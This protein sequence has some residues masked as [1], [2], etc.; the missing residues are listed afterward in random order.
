MADKAALESHLKTLRALPTIRQ[1]C[2]LVHALAQ[3]NKLQYFEYHPEKEHEVVMFCEEIMRRDYESFSKAC[4]SHTVPVEEQCARLLDLFLVSVLLDAGA[5]NVWKYKEEIENGEVYSRS[6]GLAIASLDMF[7]KGLFS[8]D[9]EMKERVDAQGLSSLDAT[10]VGEG[11]Q[12]NARNPLSGLEGR[13]GLLQKLGSAL[14]QSP[15]YFGEE[16]RVGNLLTFLKTKSLTSHA[17]RTSVHISTLWEVVMQGLA[18]IWPTDRTT[19]GGVPLGDVWRCDALANVEG[20]ATAEQKVSELEKEAHGL[21]PFHKLSQWL[22]Y[23]LVEPIEKLLGWKFEGMEDMT[24]LP[25]YRN[26]G[27]LVDLGVLKLRE[28]A[29]GREFYPDTASSIPRLPPS[30]PAII[31][32]RAMTVIELD[33]LASQLRVQTSTP[34]LSLPQV[35]EAATWKGG[36]EIAKALRA[37]VNGGGPPIEIESDGTVF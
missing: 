16:G 25:E 12:V 18:P 21:V 6:E 19:L 36:R 15:Q 1:R 27:L 33:R 30:H 35:L 13:A 26:G 10:K 8:S 37:N 31:E 22:T 7:K 9:P 3:Q 11:L 28:G 32:W 14:T 4:I 5:G 17:G 34:S 29:L 2:K 20:S 23:S 24:G